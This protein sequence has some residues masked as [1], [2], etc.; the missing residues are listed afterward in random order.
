MRDHNPLEARVVTILGVPAVDLGSAIS[1]VSIHGENTPPSGRGGSIVGLTL[2]HRIRSQ[3]GSGNERTCLFYETASIHD[4]PKVALNTKQRVNRRTRKKL[5]R[6]G[7]Q[8]LQ[9]G[10]RPGFCG[11]RHRRADSHRLIVTFKPDYKRRLLG[12]EQALLVQPVVVS[13]GVG[14]DERTEGIRLRTG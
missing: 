6:P 12:S 7:K 11:T 13:G 3:R 4:S 8:L 10:S 14:I 5:D 2:R 9:I 1:P